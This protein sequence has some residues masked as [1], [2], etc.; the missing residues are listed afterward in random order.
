MGQEVAVKSLLR[1]W[2]VINV[3]QL[4]CVYMLWRF[5][6]RRRLAQAVEGGG[7]DGRDETGKPEGV[8]RYEA[9]EY[10]RLPLNDL[11]PLDSSDDDSDA[12]DSDIRRNKYGA[13]KGAMRGDRGSGADM[14]LATD[15]DH[16]ERQREDHDGLSTTPSSALA[17]TD[18]ERARSRVFLAS[19]LAWI[20]LVWVVFLV[21]A[22]L[23][24]F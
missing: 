17:R 19:S 18:N 3:L 6:R 9:E 22:Y 7:H 20:G 15:P 11:P 24:L 12:D 23:D 8:S 2:L 13:G 4:L 5:E 14:Y 16:V 1:A 10:E 21:D